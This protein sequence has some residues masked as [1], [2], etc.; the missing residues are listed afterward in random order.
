MATLPMMPPPRGEPISDSAR[1]GAGLVGGV[2][3]AGFLQMVVRH[4]AEGWLA[5]LALGGPMVWLIQLART[6]SAR[7][8][9]SLGWYGAWYLLFA[10]GWL[11][12]RGLQHASPG[13]LLGPQASIGVFLGSVASV[14]SAS[15]FPHWRVRLRRSRWPSPA[16]DAPTHHHS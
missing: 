11:A 8:A 12:A 13:E 1:Y 4:P 10:A 9:N 15:R 2:L 14:G 16:P 3:V 7:Q 6:G 5:A